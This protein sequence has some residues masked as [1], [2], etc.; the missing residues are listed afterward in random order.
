MKS[1]YIHALSTR[2][3]ALSLEVASTIARST[4]HAEQWAR[5]LAASTAKTEAAERHAYQCQQSSAVAAASARE[6]EEI[7]AERDSMLLTIARNS[8]EALQGQILPTA[9]WFVQAPCLP[10]PHR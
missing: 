6:A 5:A 7:R 1:L 3:S 4:L 10:R 8:A 2:E 9:S